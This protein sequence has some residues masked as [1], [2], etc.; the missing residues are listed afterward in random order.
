MSPPSEPLRLLLEL[1]SCEDPIQG[2]IGHRDDEGLVPFA[3]WLE[4][5][6]VIGR[7]TGSSA[8]T[9]STT[10]FPGGA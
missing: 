5:M 3:G 8:P 6:T 2:R 10:A 7:L 9:P 1:D 4:L